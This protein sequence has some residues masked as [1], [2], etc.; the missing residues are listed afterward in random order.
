MNG[1]REFELPGLTGTCH[2]KSPVF[3]VILATVSCSI[4]L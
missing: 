3:Y 1:N 4:Y 2:L